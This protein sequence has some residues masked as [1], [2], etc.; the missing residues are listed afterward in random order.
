MLAK[1]LLAS[2]VLSF[3]AGSLEVPI[4]ARQSVGNYA[5]F[6]LNEGD[7]PLSF[8]DALT[9]LDNIAGTEDQARALC[10]S[11]DNCAVILSYDDS[12]K[13]FLHRLST[14]N[15]GLFEIVGP[16]QIFYRY[17]RPSRPICSSATDHFEIDGHCVCGPAT[18]EQ[19]PISLFGCRPSTPSTKS[20][21]R[22]VRRPGMK[23]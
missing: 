9:P 2:L 23:H 1:V 18:E 12:G 22:S 10:E 5:Q 7:E 17:D 13:Y 21:K 16:W 3:S 15:S 20:K 8:A 19:D 4:A 14:D 11:Y 6:T